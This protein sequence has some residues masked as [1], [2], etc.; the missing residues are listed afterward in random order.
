MRGTAQ[1]G[2]GSSRWTRA[3]IT[4]ASSGI[5][6][7]IARRLAADHVELVLVARRRERLREVGQEL[8]RVSGRPV[9]VVA[10]DLTEDADV[11]RVEARLSSSERPVDLLVNNAGGG[12]LS[13]FPGGTPEEEARSIRLNATAIVRLTAAVLPGMRERHCGTILNV[14]SG[15]GLQPSG[16]AAVYGASKA[17]VNSFSEAIREENRN[18]GVSVTVVCPGFTRTGLPARTGFDVSKVPRFLWMTAD[19]VAA[20]ALAAAARGRGLSFPGFPNKLGDAVA[21]HAPRRLVASFV[22]RGTRGMLNE[23]RER[24]V[25]APEDRGRRNHGT[26]SPSRRIP[27][28]ISSS[29]SEP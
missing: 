23:D 1:R 20:H 28:R 12:Q 14:S 27:S 29:E 15:S 26:T 10:A 19:D 11:L 25:S 22:A 3:L 9:E 16:Y 17:F 7:A 24:E 21:K 5:G 18:Y 8:E 13:L 6:E 4:G 2:P